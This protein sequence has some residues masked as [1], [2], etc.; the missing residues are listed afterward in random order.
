MQ[1]LIIDDDEV[2]TD[3]LKNFLIQQNIERDNI[4]ISRDAADARKKLGQFNVD[5]MLLDVLLPARQG[6]KASGEHS[7]ELLRQIVEDGVFPAPK[8]IIGITASEDAI[9]EFNAEFRG[10]ITQVLHVSPEL[11]DWKETLFNFLEYLKRV[12][13][14]KNSFDYDVVV[15]NA[16]RKPELEAVYDTWNLNLGEEH[17]VGSNISCRK[18]MLS[19]DG[20][21]LKIACAHLSQMGPIVATQTTECILSLFKPRMLI[22]TGICGGFSDSVNVGDV[23]IADKSWDWQA[24]KWVE[25]WSLLSALD[26]KDA[27]SEL[28]TLAKTIDRDM[29]KFHQDYKYNRPAEVPNLVWGPMVTGS[30]V[31]AA[32]DIQNVFKTQ[33]R[34]MCAIDMECYGLYYSC[35]QHFGSKTKFICIKA[36]SDLADRDKADNFQKYCSYMSA[37]VGLK[38]VEKYFRSF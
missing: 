7:I 9:Q 37:R 28:V 24:G 25:D 6:S 11:D 18:G 14:S 31:V 32:K 22:M 10:V 23:V 30:S 13:I 33:H 20:K 36:V 38:L 35:T 29:E 3:R 21:D 19:I 5:L 15:L 4:L 12:E 16:L 8:N 26:P 17:L 34:K 27:S 1:V 2:K